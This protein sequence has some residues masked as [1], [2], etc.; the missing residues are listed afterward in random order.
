MGLSNTQKA[1]ISYLI[2]T[3]EEDNLEDFIEAIEGVKDF[4]DKFEAIKERLSEVE[5]KID[6]HLIDHTM[7]EFKEED[8]IFD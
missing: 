4:S 5:S 8:G 7:V 2:D 3:L 1:I 6:N